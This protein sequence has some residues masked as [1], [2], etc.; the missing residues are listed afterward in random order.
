MCHVHADAVIG[1]E[2]LFARDQRTLGQR[3]ALRTAGT[4]KFRPMPFRCREHNVL[5]A[6]SLSFVSN[7]ASRRIA[8]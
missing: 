6:A 5:I 1:V 3:Y 8:R 4:Q 2:D 7:F